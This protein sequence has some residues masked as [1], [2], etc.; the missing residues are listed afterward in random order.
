MTVKGTR[1]C[2]EVSGLFSENAED[3]NNEGKAEKI[4]DPNE[5][6]NMNSAITKGKYEHTDANVIRNAEVRSLTL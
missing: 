1:V 6:K 4:N 3:P 5:Y 2:K